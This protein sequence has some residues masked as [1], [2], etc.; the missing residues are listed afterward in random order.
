[1][2]SALKAFERTGNVWTQILPSILGG[3]QRNYYFVYPG[4]ETIFMTHDK[5][6]FEMHLDKGAIEYTGEETL[7]PDGAAK[8]SYTYR[9]KFYPRRYYSKRRRR[10]RRFTRRVYHRNT[11]HK[12]TYAKKI[13]K[14]KQSYVPNLYNVKKLRS[15]RSGRGAN[16]RV[17]SWSEHPFINRSFY[18]KMYTGTGTSLWKTR[19]LP[20]TPYTIKY[21]IKSSWAYL[22]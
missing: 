20:V 19:L 18:K 16:V 5:D 8:K 3:A 10:R 22:R 13:F 2:G 17:A 7:I 1:M 11:Y 9:R 14:P 21:R 4:S 6:V 15:I 12:K